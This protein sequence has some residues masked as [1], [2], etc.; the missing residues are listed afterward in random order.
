MSPSGSIEQFGYLMVYTG[1]TLPEGSERKA[2]AIEPMTCPPD[3]FR[4]GTDLV[5]L[6]PGDHWTGTWGV[7]VR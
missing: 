1:D 4:S 7:T 6:Q 3:A 5:V 2:V